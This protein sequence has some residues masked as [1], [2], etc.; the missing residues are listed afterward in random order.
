MKIGVGQII[1]MRAGAHQRMNYCWRIQE[2]GKDTTKKVFFLFLVGNINR[3]GCLG[4]IERPFESRIRQQ[5]L[6]AV[7]PGIETCFKNMDK[8][9]LLFPV[10]S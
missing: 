3:L 4:E 6:R 1:F 10:L 2:V 8:Y 9:R 5:Y 7:L